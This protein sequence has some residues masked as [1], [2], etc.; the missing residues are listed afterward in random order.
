MIYNVRVTLLQPKKLK[1][2]QPG[3]DAS[4]KVICVISKMFCNDVDSK[5][6]SMGLLW[7]NYW[8][9][10]V[11]VSLTIAIPWFQ[12]ILTKFILYQS[13]KLSEMCN[14]SWFSTRLSII[15]SSKGSAA[16]ILLSSIFVWARFLPWCIAGTEEVEFGSAVELI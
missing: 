1:Q 5:N 7:K 9:I 12:I 16:E 15:T 8:K 2:W 14:S 4:K 13:C 6:G 11:W 3:V 10:I